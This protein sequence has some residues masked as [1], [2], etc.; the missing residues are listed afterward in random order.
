MACHNIQVYTSHN[1]SNGDKITDVQ[2]KKDTVQNWLDNHQEVLKTQSSEFSSANT[3]I[4]G[5][6]TDYYMG[7]FRFHWDENPTQLKDDIATWLTNNFEWWY[8]RYHECDHDQEKRSGCSWS[9]EWE[10]GSVPNDI[11]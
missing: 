6:G 1:D 10:H 2:S 4:G 3:A 5:E 8:V 9:N 11:P 7:S